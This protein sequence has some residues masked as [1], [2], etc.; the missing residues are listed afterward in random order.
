MELQKLRGNILKLSGDWDIDMQVIKT[1]LEFNLG[2]CNGLCTK[3]EIT[4]VSIGDI[5]TE[6]RLGKGWKVQVTTT[7]EPKC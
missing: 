6:D 4:I 3:H 2:G 1:A 7:Y 5:E